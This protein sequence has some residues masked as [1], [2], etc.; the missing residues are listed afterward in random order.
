[1][2]VTYIGRMKQTD[3]LVVKMTPE[4]KDALFAMVKA[5]ND[6]NPFFKLSASE[7]ARRAIV[8]KLTREARAELTGRPC[9]DA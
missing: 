9:N 7:Y 5:E 1:M 4:L 3:T 8:E 6:S 2:V